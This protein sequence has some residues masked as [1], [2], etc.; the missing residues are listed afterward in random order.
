MGIS[1]FPF[2][3]FKSSV[4]VRARKEGGL[5]FPCAIGR[6]WPLDLEVGRNEVVEEEMVFNIQDL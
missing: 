5:F 3:K 1:G 4:L 6:R 2:K